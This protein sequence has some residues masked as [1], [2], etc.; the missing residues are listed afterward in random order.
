MKIKLTFILFL[1]FLSYKSQYLIIGNDSISVQ[2]FKEENKY[3]LETAGINST[4]KTYTD[5]KLLQR[6]ALDRKADTLSYFKTKMAERD[7]ALREEYFYPKEIM[8]NTLNQ[9]FSANQIESKIQVFYVQKEEKDIND[10]NKI[11]NDVKN[12]NLKIEEAISKY[13]KLKAEPFYVKA[14]TVDME[15]EKELLTLQP[16]AYTNLINTPTLAAFAKLVERRPSLGYLIFGTISYPKSDAE[17][18]KTQIYEALKSGE[19]FEEV[20]KLYG[21]TDSE[22]NNAGVIMGSPVLPDE[23][24]AAL[25]NKKEGEYTEPVLLGDKY[26]IFNVYSLIPYQNSEKHNKMFIKELMQSQYADVAYEKLVNSLV[27]SSKYKEYPDF[28]KVK[29]SYQD[30][31]NFKN[32]KAPFYK[33]GNN[34]F[35]YEDL[36]KSIAE[37]FKNADK[38]PSN[39]WKLFLESKRD[40]DVF[41]SYGKEFSDLPEVKSEMTKL[42]QNLLAEYI[43]NHYVENELKKT[44]LLD[45]YYQNHKDKFIL[46]SRADGRVAILT[47]LSLEKDITKEIENPKNWENLNKKYYGKLNEKQQ[48]VVHFEKGEMSENADVFR[49]NNVP[50]KKGIHK[51]KMNDKLLIIAIDDILPPSQMSRTDAE[52]QL[53]T[54][55]TEEILTKTIREQRNKTKITIESAFMAELEKNFKK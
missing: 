26:F 6:F 17:K 31:I 18:M 5:F 54:E 38:L 8:Q 45:E 22:K 19:K 41:I 9:Y 34:I 52:E 46:E 23:V 13:S 35:M 47:D 36:K 48:I 40:N 43:F 30:F 20:A 11:Y 33:Y 14:G 44:Q 2:K 37:N 27:K 51:V 10:Y 55:V 3:G 29:K 50:F 24:Y 7:Q 15:L 28:E 21:S 42:K 49:V 39:Q 12:G 4:I 1:T 53:K 25:K 16:G 32:P